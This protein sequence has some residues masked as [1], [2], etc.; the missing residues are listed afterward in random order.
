MLQLRSYTFAALSLVGVLALSSCSRGGDAPTP[1]PSS[2]KNTITI[3]K[4]SPSSLKTAAK[5]KPP[6]ENKPATTG[7]AATLG[8]GGT[9]ERFGSWTVMQ[10]MEPY[11]MYALANAEIPADKAKAYATAADPGVV[12]ARVAD[13]QFGPEVAGIRSWCILVTA[14]AKSGWA[15]VVAAVPPQGEG[16]QATAVQGWLPALTCKEVLPTKASESAKLLDK[17]GAVRLGTDTIIDL[18]AQ[19]SELHLTPTGQKVL[20]KGKEADATRPE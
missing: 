1:D 18:L 8:T 5:S 19:A 9:A 4:A 15:L 10:G 13:V 7:Q 6:A 12:G 16:G 2:S 3:P 17:Q 14:G 20:A 11:K